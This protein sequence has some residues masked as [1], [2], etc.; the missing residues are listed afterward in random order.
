ML[1][2]SCAEFVFFAYRRVESTFAMERYQIPV[3]DLTYLI[4][5][6]MTYYYNDQEVI[7]RAGDAIL[8]PQGSVRQRLE[9]R[10]PVQYASINVK[11]PEDQISELEGEPPLAGHLPGR[12][13][14]TVVS[15]LE[16]MED[17]WYSASEFADTQCLA[18][19][20]YLYYQLVSFKLESQNPYVKNIKRYIADH[21]TDKLTLQEISDSV[22]LA[23][24]YCCS[25]FKKNTGKTLFAYILEQRID[26]AKRLIKLGEV[27]LKNIAGDVGFSDYNYFSRTF[28]R[29][30]GLTPREYKHLTDRK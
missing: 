10:S 1:D 12:T 26:T 27:S 23:P 2:L 14:A 25:L 16:L 29:I 28:R 3:M 20:T 13:T 30:T 11:F 18:L 17:I 22:C 21:I 6:E 24:E 9:V 8:F 7:L 4:S 15:V 19:F 5:G